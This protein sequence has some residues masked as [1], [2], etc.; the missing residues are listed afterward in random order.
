M[1]KRKPKPCV[2]HKW[3]IDEWGRKPPRYNHE[4]HYVCT[5][6]GETHHGRLESRAL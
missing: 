5:K 1:P 3:D 6:C 4:E 2:Q